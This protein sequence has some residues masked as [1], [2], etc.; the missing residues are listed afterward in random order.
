MEIKEVLVQYADLI[1][2]AEELRK[3]IEKT[4]YEIDRIVSGK[5]G[6]VDVVQ[7]TTNDIR[8]A[9]CLITIRGAD[10]VGYYRKK[11]N[12][13]RY[14]MQLENLEQ[15]VLEQLT[16]AQEYIEKIP[17]SRMR[18]IMTYRY[19]DNLKWYQIAQRIG[20][21]CTWD[22]IRKEHDRYLERK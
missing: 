18:R 8:Y 16:L 7:G 21:K 13:I 17:D 22:S 5:N 4:Q 19:M 6:V 3:R 20:G 9:P 14:R 15:R 12:L 1:Q 2:E 11:R 10:S